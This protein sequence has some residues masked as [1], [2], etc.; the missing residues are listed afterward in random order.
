E[1]PNPRLI[2]GRLGNESAVCQR[3]IV[4]LPTKRM[5]SFGTAFWWSHFSKA[6]ISVSNRSGPAGFFVVAA[7]G[8]AGALVGPFAKATNSVGYKK[9]QKDTTRKNDCRTR[10]AF[11]RCA[12]IFVTFCVFCG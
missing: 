1:P 10:D 7:D 6:A 4:E 5:Q 12:F 9:A 2:T 8:A 3:R 11:N